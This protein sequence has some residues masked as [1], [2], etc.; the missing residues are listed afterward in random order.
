MEVFIKSVILAPIFNIA[1][2]V[3]GLNLAFS[4]KT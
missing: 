3:I 2:A 1:F 4:K